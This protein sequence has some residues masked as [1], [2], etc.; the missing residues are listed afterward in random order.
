MSAG[1]KL[2]SRARSR[3][4]L[5]QGPYEYL[6][7]PRVGRIL[8]LSH[9]PISQCATH[10]YRSFSTRA[11]PVVSQDPD[12]SKIGLESS[13]TDIG[14]YA[15]I[16]DSNAA[17]TQTAPALSRR[18]ILTRELLRTMARSKKPR[19]DERRRT[20]LKPTVQYASRR[21][22]RQY[23]RKRTAIERMVSLNESVSTL[24]HKSSPDW[25]E[26]IEFM[27]DHTNTVD[28]APRAHVPKVKPPECLLKA[29]IAKTAIT[30]AMTFSEFEQN[31]ERIQ[32]KQ[33]CGI[34][35]ETG[36]SEEGPVILYIWGIIGRIRDT[37]RA[38]VK[39]LGIMSDDEH[40]PRLQRS[41]DGPAKFEVTIMDRD[42]FAPRYKSYTLTT[43]PE[44]IRKPDT[45]TESSLEKYVA[46]LVLARMPPDLSRILYPHG[47]SHHLIVLD[48]LLQI[49]T[50]QYMQPLVTANT[51]KMALRYVLLAGPGSR[52]TARA[53]MSQAELNGM[54]IDAETFELFLDDAAKFADLRLFNSTLRGMCKQGHSVGPGA[55]KALL[56]LIRDD[57]IK[58]RAMYEITVRGVINLEGIETE[59]LREC[60]VINARTEGNMDNVF[61]ILEVYC[62]RFGTSWVDTI[63]LNK[64]LVELGSHGNLQACYKLLDRMEGSWDVPLSPYT[65]SIMLMHEP[66]IPQKLA[67]LSRW[68]RLTHGA[69][70]YDI[71]FDIFW[72]RRHPNM[73]RVMWRYAALNGFTNSKM[74]NLLTKVIRHQPGQPGLR[75]IYLKTWEDVIFGRDELAA[76]RA[77]Y[78]DGSQGVGLA[79]LIKQYRQNAGA[80]RPLVPLG[81]KLLEAYHLDQKI[82]LVDPETTPITDALR[83]SLTVD[84]PL[85]IMLL[86]DRGRKA[87]GLRHAHLNLPR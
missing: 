50:S 17:H 70:A 9:H 39:T 80:K 73:L 51:L 87:S 60:M 8:T 40:L 28:V 16:A 57:N 78:G 54:P 11:E 22:T 3:G 65:L 48:H 56:R 38:V 21:V 43:R 37:L 69:V 42:N 75:Y 85:G 76:G 74:N 26:M 18:G 27:F 2:L 83:D 68:P 36:S 64:V 34:S 23:E 47:Q 20:T 15:S 6:S 13:K 67:L 30:K 41:R 33:G 79:Q 4:V 24:L 14:A 63:T 19:G 66:S 52:P 86:K 72:K 77:F 46:D 45:W 84:I 12:T 44:E 1:L 7:L 58:L 62:N 5:P 35:L 49:F 71:L 59:V 81:T 61:D 55:W 32:E 31:I 29:T 25:L 82:H 53:I 10:C